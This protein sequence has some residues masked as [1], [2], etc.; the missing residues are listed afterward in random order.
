MGQR[1]EL[2]ESTRRLYSRV[3]ALADPSRFAVWE[4]FGLTMSQLRVLMILNRHPGTTSGHLADRLGVRA[5]TVTGIVDRLVRQDLVERQPD[6]DDRRVVRNGL[7]QRGTEVVT[8]MS[9]AGR[10]YTRNILT[11]MSDTELN[12]LHDALH[13]LTAK[14]EALGLL[15]A[16]QPDAVADSR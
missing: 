6:A 15:Q 2:M 7:T 5:S 3:V 14:A 12:Q 11:T 8:Q 13:I 10:E 1:E 4:D 16:A 9:A